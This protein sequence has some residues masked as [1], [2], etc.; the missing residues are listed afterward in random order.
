MGSR[1][2]LFVAPS[3]GQ[4]PTLDPTTSSTRVCPTLSP[5]T[6]P[7]NRS[8]KWRPLSNNGAL[9]SIS[10]RQTP[11]THQLSQTRNPSLPRL[12]IL[13][14]SLHQT[15]SRM[16]DHR[17]LMNSDHLLGQ[18]RSRHFATTL[19]TTNQSIRF[20]CLRS[21]LRAD[22]VG[23]QATLLMPMINLISTQL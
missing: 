4:T 15:T 2:N 19:R 6:T 9:S 23:T 14:I 8:P 22:P 3:L 17:A 5:T 1:L 21:R 18:I 10:L 16:G 20:P 12:R 7:T 13:A 11:R